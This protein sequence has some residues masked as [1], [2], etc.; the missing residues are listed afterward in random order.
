MKS[1]Q[2]QIA[3]LFLAI[4]ASSPW[5]VCACKG[6]PKF[7]NVSGKVWLLVEVRTKDENIIFDRKNLDAEGFKDIFTLNFDAE[8]MSGT[9]APNRYTAPFSLEKNQAITVK[10]VA[11][12]M[13]AAIR[14]PEKLKEHDFF[15]YLQNTSK[16]NL[17]KG[18]L[19]LYTKNENDEE[20]VMVFALGS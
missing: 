9:G 4:I 15:T 13:M 8:R 17:V 6:T 2:K 11:G 7:S 16:W 1:L 12:T 5:G 19:E 14:E 3:T 10:P 18:K 20:A